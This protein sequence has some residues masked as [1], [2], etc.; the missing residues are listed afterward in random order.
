MAEFSSRFWGYRHRALDAP[1][2][3]HL[4]ALSRRLFQWIDHVPARLT[5]F[6]F[7]VVGNFEEAI[8]AARRR[9]AAPQEASGR[10]GGRCGCSW[11]CGGRPT[12]Q[13]L[14]RGLK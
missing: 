9:A 1:A 10:C 13:D 6:G 14:Q 8:G 12:A 11:R 3:D 4:L 7:A 5:A 2:D